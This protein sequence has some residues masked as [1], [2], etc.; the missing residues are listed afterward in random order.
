MSQCIALVYDLEKKQ[1]G[2]FIPKR[3][4][5]NTHNSTNLCLQ[6]Q[7]KVSKYCEACSKNSGNKTTHTEQWQHLGTY[8]E[9][10]FVFEEYKDDLMK[11]HQKKN[12]A[13]SKTSDSSSK[14]ESTETKIHDLEYDDELGLWVDM[15]NGL[16]FTSEDP[17]E[18]A[19]GYIDKNGNYKQFP[20]IAD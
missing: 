6:H 14:D 17:D 2:T 20:I 9:P 13:K 12:E 19:I 5:R 15:D 10:S 11:K 3:C 18:E 1:D 4:T 16:C 7:K 8:L